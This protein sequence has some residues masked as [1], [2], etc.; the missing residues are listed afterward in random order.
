MTRV[1]L[2]SALAM[3]M[4]ATRPT[5]SPAGSY[6]TELPFS[7]GTGGRVSALGLAGS[8]LTGDPG[9][10][11][12]NPATLSQMRYKKLELFRTTFFDS[13]STYYSVSY[14]H[15]MLNYGTLAATVLRL[16]VGG[17]EE[18]DVDNVLLSTDMKNA[19]TRLLLGYAVSLHSALSAGL[20]LKVDNQSFGGFSGSGIGLDLGFLG[21]KTFAEGSRLHYIRGGF[22]I[23]NLI[24][25]SV[26]LDQDDVADPMSVM[27]GGSAVAGAGH[28]GFVTLIDFV[29]PRYSP[30]QVRFGQEVTYNDI[31]AFRFGF[32]GS[33]PTVGGGVSWRNVAVD[34]AYR[35]E[36]LGSN[37][38]ISVT[39]GFGASLDD[40]RSAER[41]QREAELDRQINE[42]MVELESAQL[43]QTLARADGLLAQAR[44]G[45]AAVQYELA[46]LWDADN[47]AARAR[48]E[49]CR[50][51]E[52]VD[53]AH[54]L[55]G[56][57]QYLEALYH[58][59]RALAH[60]P[61]DPEATALLAECNRRIR[62]QAD[63]TEMVNR[64]MKRSIDL[65]ATRRFVEANAGFREILNL[66]PDNEL[67][68]EYEQ[69][70]YTNIQNQKQQAVIEANGLADRGEYAAAIAA[71]EGALR[72]DPD[73]SYLKDRIA[74]LEAKQLTADRDRAQHREVVRV[75]T[76]TVRPSA[77]ESALQLKYSEGLK[78][79]EEGDFD[80]A[81]RRLHEVWIVEPGYHN[82]TELL[83]KTYVFIGLKSY[84]EER[85]QDAIVTWE[86]ALTVDPDNVKARRYLRKAKE[87][88]SRLSS[89]E[90][91]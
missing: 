77:D 62:S 44:Y 47:Q 16:D 24:E 4:L 8:S 42:K 43:T 35:S 38:R 76:P 2:C 41:Q 39:V 80:R 19:Q 89:V 7:A 74:E 17:I 53:Q 5:S 71:L 85:Y 3:F 21:T 23:L 73:D 46:L 50:Y 25:P 54:E 37:H 45:E 72:I 14:G 52:A 48:L 87:E 49:T 33:T 84:S 83:T 61:D 34:Y 91:G 22:S 10:Q 88:A 82:V 67:A 27:F 59:R 81:V 55:M 63:H 18:R 90:D 36:D 13:K 11:Q 32:E 56:D 57:R 31:L 70:S 75:Q 51:H 60:S 28:I 64:M 30:F 29:A 58:L 9:L 15:P 26:K 79:F 78:Y 1:V 65:Y 69:K 6:G 20:N 40:R 86:R 68:T 12:F 66:D